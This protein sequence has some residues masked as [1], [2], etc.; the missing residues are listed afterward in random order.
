MPG[1]VEVSF[2][3]LDS[4][5]KLQQ[6]ARKSPNLAKDGVLTPERIRRYKA[7]G[8]HLKMLYATERV[9]DEIL[10]AL[11]AL[12]QE[13]NALPK[14]RKMQSGEVINCIK[15][16]PSENR[17][18]LHTA[19]RDFF[20]GAAQAGPAFEARALAKT[21]C[22]KLHDFLTNIE[23]KFNTLFMIGIG[24]SDLGPS[25][26]YTGLEHLLKEGRKIHFI[27]NIDPDSL[28]MA[29]KGADLEK[30][31]A[32]VVSKSGSTLETKTN[33]EFM[34]ALFIKQGLKPEKHFI[35]VTGEGSAM[36]N[37][38]KYVKVFYIWDWIGG[39]YSST[40]MV[41]GV[42]LGFAFGF[43]VFFEILKGA[44]AMDKAALIEDP[45]K[46]LPLLGALFSIWNRNLLGLPTLAIIPYSQG[47]SRFPAHIQ[48]VSME[49][50][51]KHIDRFGNHV[52][53][54]TGMVIWGEP[55]TNAQHSFFQLI[56]Q[57]TEVV[58][59]EFIGFEKNRMH[60]DFQFEKTSSQEKLIAN[61]IAQS[62]SLAL[63]QK[64]T[65]PNKEFI[66]NRPSH[67]IIGE[68]LTPA[69]IGAILAYFEHKVAFEGFIWNINSFDQEGVQLGKLLASKVLDRM[70]KQGEPFPLADAYI[71]QFFSS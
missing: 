16:Y 61:L 50:N 56:H 55:G 53:Y 37:P 70:T 40:S 10:S 8:A 45:Y 1:T 44:N 19:T 22:D 54:E 34:R 33:E 49:S 35:A 63:G 17:A 27:N 68:E 13:S 38:A 18:V 36:D 47:L 58:P 57:G 7:S 2:T 31:L 65:N 67:M 4:M 69:S 48:Q 3:E 26:I 41:G 62:L 42:L 11:A 15:G 30:S 14:M 59:L 20:E 21:E 25:A 71:E 39:R 46:N 66:G 6:L 52:S 32:V 24:G 60:K 9:D 12:S 28:S 43:D 23:G 64:S 5:K 29:V 51:G